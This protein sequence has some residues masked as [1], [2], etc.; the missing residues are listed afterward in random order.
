MRYSEVPTLIED[1]GEGRVGVRG[2]GWDV[3][4]AGGDLGGAGGAEGG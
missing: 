1:G 4:G 3:V 2:G